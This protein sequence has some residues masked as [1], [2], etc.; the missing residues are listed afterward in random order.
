MFQYST[1]VKV[2][3]T[4]YE[5]RVA[6]NENGEWYILDVGIRLPRQRE[7]RYQKAILSEELRYSQ[8]PY[9]ERLNLIQEKLEEIIETDIYKKVLI[10]AWQSI[11][12]NV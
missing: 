12:P 7:F 5:V 8:V 1:K 6:L 9:Q 2:D 4:E 10:E 3:K 11:M